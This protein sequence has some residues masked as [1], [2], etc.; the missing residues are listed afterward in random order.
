MQQLVTVMHAVPSDT[1][2]PSSPLPVQIQ[3]LRLTVVRVIE[4]LHVCMYVTGFITDGRY[5]RLPIAV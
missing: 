2:L 4:C 1:A 5:R 3:A